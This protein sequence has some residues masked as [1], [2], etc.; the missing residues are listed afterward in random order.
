MARPTPFLILPRCEGAA[1]VAY[2]EKVVEDDRNPFDAITVDQRAHAVAMTREAEA[3]QDAREKEFMMR[4]VDRKLGLAKEITDELGWIIAARVFEIQKSA[5]IRS[6]QRVVKAEVGGGSNDFRLIDHRVGI[7]SKRAASFRGPIPDALPGRAQTPRDETRR[8]VGAG[9]LRV[10]RLEAPDSLVDRGD[11]LADGEA[12]F[13]CDA[14]ILRR[15]GRRRRPNEVRGGLDRRRV[16][17]LAREPPTFDEA[18]ER[19]A[20]RRVARQRRRGPPRRKTARML[21]KIPLGAKPVAR[22]VGM[23]EIDFE[24]RAPSLWKFD[25]KNAIVPAAWQRLGA[26]RMAQSR[27]FSETFSKS[28]RRHACG[29]GEESSVAARAGQLP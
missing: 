28:E 27:R 12:S 16:D 2:G 23:A 14:E 8:R 1:P 29:S 13:R 7:K 10:D 11:M 6:A 24:R 18:M 15:S 25:A 3:I 17:F 9:R 21:K 20:G 4:F 5:S 22:I 26:Q 19:S